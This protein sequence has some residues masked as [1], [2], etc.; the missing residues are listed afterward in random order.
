MASFDHDAASGNYHIRFRF[1]GKPFKRA[2]RLEDEKEAARVCGVVEEA[3]KDVKR[4][5]LA[6][7][8]G[9]EVGAFLLSGGKIDG[10]RQPVSKPCQ[11]TPSALF[12]TYERDLTAGSK[13]DNSLATERI[14]R[15]H[16]LGHFRK[17]AIAGIDH[18]AIQGYVNIRSAAGVTAVT[19]RKELA[20]LRMIWNWG[21]HNGHVN[22]PLP[23]KMKRLKFPKGTRREQFQTWEQIGRKVESLRRAGELTEERESRLWECLYLDEA[24]VKDCLEH[25]RRNA[26]Y[27]FVHPMF[28]FCAYTGARRSE[29]LRS[30][31]SDWDLANGTVDIR[32]KKEDSSQE[33]TLRQVPIHPALS[34]VMRVWFDRHPG[35]P[36]TI[37]TQNQKQIGPRMAT[38]YFTAVL[39]GSKWSILRGFH[40]FRHSL[41]SIMASQGIDQ[42]IINE[43]LGHST[44]EMVR[45]YRHLSPQKREQAMGQLFA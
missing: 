19:I 25:V 27:P 4:G 22:I 1:G 36:F 21:V 32:Q 40:V 37:C 42:R 39:A 18:Q 7:P 28:A 35:G 5:R 2:L 30:E 6:I 34:E 43:I 45:R 8:P 10:T 44:E 14:H 26:A 38:K 23:W 31:L 13:E 41:A 33:Y 20:T 24:Q 12:A 15:R 16:L 29:I 11:G 17:S 3:I 9:A